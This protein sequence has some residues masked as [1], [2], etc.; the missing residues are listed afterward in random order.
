[1]TANDR[2]PSRV[3]VVGQIRLQLNQAEQEGLRNSTSVLKKIADSMELTER[4]A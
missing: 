1:M 3:A 4:P 2:K